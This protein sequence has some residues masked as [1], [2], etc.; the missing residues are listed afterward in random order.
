MT[1]GSIY[2]EDAPNI[3]APKN[4]RQIPTNLKGETG[5]NTVIV[6]DI[7]IPPPTMAR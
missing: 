3:V 5:N 4:A 7:S 2:Q 1:K 6:D